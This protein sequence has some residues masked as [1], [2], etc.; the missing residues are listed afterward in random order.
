MTFEDVLAG[1]WYS[2]FDSSNISGFGF[3]GASGT[4]T[5]E[6]HGGRTY[7]YYGVPPELV[8]QWMY[9]PSKGVFH[10]REIKYEYTYQEI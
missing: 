10:A 4:L 1:G 5:V 7:H 8:Q 6:F 9:A 2:E 3:D